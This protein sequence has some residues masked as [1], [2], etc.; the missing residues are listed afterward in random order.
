MTHGALSAA[1]EFAAELTATIQAVLPHSPE[2]QAM[3][4]APPHLLISVFDVEQN[5][6]RLP[7]YI[8][9]KHVADWKLTMSV[10]FD[11]SG[12]Y[13]KVMRSGFTLLARADK[14]PLVRYE[15]DDNMHTAPIAH[16]QFHAERGAFS[17]L[18]GFAL[19]AGKPVKPH[20]LSS[21]HF[22]VGG[23]RMR[24]G[25]DDLLEF[26]VKECAFDSVG[27]WKGAIHESRAR[28]RAIQARTIARDMQDEV[29]DVLRGEGW[30]VTPPADGVAE[31]GQKFLSR[32]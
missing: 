4:V 21:L 20:S 9:G 5:V 32:W 25:V 1:K 10:N 17:H 31:P 19:A 16:W 26:L 11:S 29:A 30:T 15:F 7:L 12:D 14:L 24:P 6:G 28:Y 23:A 8:R 18:L 3:L 13:L 22:P 2:F 27:G